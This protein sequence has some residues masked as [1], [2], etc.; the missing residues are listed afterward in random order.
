MSNAELHLSRKDFR[1]EWF[2]GSGAGGQHRNKHDNCCRITH[3]ESG[4]SAVGTGSKSRVTNQRLAFSH[5]ASRLIAHYTASPTSR[6]LDGER[7]RT[8]HEPR[9]EVL[10]HRSGFTQ[11]Y[12][13]VV[14][15]N[16]IGPMI[17]ARKHVAEVDLADDIGSQSVEWGS[18][19][20]SDSKPQPNP[21]RRFAGSD[22]D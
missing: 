6:R 15:K 21:S 7:V 3:V 17:E 14:T 16:N 4:I 1:L 11:R 10:D 8:Y 20:H 18:I 12:T 5:L 13:E 9:N 19:P 2:S 22:D